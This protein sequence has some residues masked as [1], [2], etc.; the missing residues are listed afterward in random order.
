MGLSRPVGP[1]PPIRASLSAPCRSIP[2]A[3][4]RD[5]IDGIWSIE[6]AKK[7]SENARSG[8]GNP[9]KQGGCDRSRIVSKHGMA[10]PP[11]RSDRPRTLNWRERGRARRPD[12]GAA[13]RGRGCGSEACRGR[14][15]LRQKTGPGGLRLERLTDG[16]RPAF[17]R[18]SREFYQ[19]SLTVPAV[20]LNIRASPC[21][22][23][24]VAPASDRERGR[25][26]AAGRRDARG[27]MG[28]SHQPRVPSRAIPPRSGPM[29]GFSLRS[30]VV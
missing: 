25:R 19:I 16:C 11:A 9:R 23:R 13:S 2:S 4:R 6:R 21:G 29:A 22:N 15:P 26:R 3:R 28:R 8:P 7:L 12:L 10:S 17:D 30:G 14:S 18:I 1:V 20:R 24:V 27:L 5:V